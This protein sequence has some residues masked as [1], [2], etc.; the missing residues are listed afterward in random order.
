[1]IPELTRELFE[2]Y[3]GE[4]FLAGPESGPSVPLK[5][6][7]VVVAPKEACVDQK[8]QVR[9]ESYIVVFEGAPE[10]TLPQGIHTFRHEKMGE[11]AFFITPVATQSPGV[12]HYEVIFSRLV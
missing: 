4:T 1:M 9:T 12:R 3:V 11:T 8:G 6:V 7:K 5:L 10:Q 2:G